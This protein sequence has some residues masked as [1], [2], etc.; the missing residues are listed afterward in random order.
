MKILQIFNK[1]LLPGGE[2]LA[3]NQIS[4]KLAT[5][6]VVR[7]LTF[8]TK[9]WVENESFLGKIMQA[10]HMVWNPA[11]I[12]Q[13]FK[14][15]EEFQPD[16]IILHNIM[17]IGSS[18]MYP[19]LQMRGVPIIQFIHNFRPFSVNGYCWADHQIQP[20]G[21]RL[22][23]LPEIRAAGWQNSRLKT[24]WYALQLR[25]LHASGTFQNINGWV[26]ISHFMADTFADCGIPA[27]K[28]RVIPHSWEIKQ[29]TYN[30]A[31][32]ADTEPTFLF[33]GRISEEK[34]LR[35]LLDA[36]KI[37]EQSGLP[38][39]LIIGGDGP[40]LD[41]AKALCKD[42]NHAT[43][44]GYVQGEAKE[45]LLKECTALVIPSIW[46][47]PMGLVIFEAFEFNKP[48]LAA[49]SG[50]IVDHVSDPDTGWLH[51][52]GDYMQLA[53]HFKEA[54]GNPEEIVRRGANARVY[55]ETQND[56]LWLERFENFAEHII[57]LH[58]DPLKSPIQPSQAKPNTKRKKSTLQVMTYL[59]DQNPRVGRSLGISRMTNIVM[60]SLAS[61]EDLELGAVVSRSSVKAPKNTQSVITL[62]WSTRG[63]VLRMF[64]DNLHPLFV[65]PNQRPDVWYFPKGFM[66]RISGA[67]T[68]SIATIHDTIIQYYQDNYPRWRLD[69]EYNYWSGMLKNTLI[70]A[71]E[72]MTV[73]NHAK[74][75]I[76]DFID[77]HHL[78][79]RHIH[80]TYE[81][82]LYE[83]IPQPRSS[84][85]SDY[86]MHLSSVEPHKR[87]KWL[88]D[89]WILRSKTGHK[90]H[91][92]KL[93]VIG[94]IP[95][96][97]LS[98]VEK[99]DWI[100]HL[101]FLEDN[102]LIRQ[103]ASAKALMLPSEIE[104]FGLPA[105]E[106][107]YLGTPTCFVKDTSVE[108]ILVPATTKGGF[109]LDQPDSLWGAL[110]EVLS[111]SEAEVYDCGIILRET[112]HTSKIANAMVAV[113]RE[114]AEIN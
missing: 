4:V 11:A 75:Q 27:E 86:V 26:A 111:M 23:F 87:T 96:D 51:E 108:E 72:I 109:H 48:V 81:P 44:L 45:K 113:F 92:P 8:H 106:A 42:M 61:R 74:S 15:I 89:Q 34:G 112:Y 24:A 33:L 52:P 3:V 60:R 90:Q 63:R 98:S 80:V 43:C 105:L 62:P 85:K 68:P 20:D 55:L 29:K 38:G 54:A 1:Y 58:K 57:R 73:S 67:M 102:E 104:G 64:T 59:A 28:I 7:D 71:S 21:L 32:P 46:W 69:I 82:C 103:Y 76:E 6:H 37:H 91:L 101:P 79:K 93:H 83:S 19:A 70:H 65:L 49:K 78:P 17:P 22:N 47:E 13:A 2:E 18:M 25:A 12:R 36:W 35:V 77:R 40:L 99:C 39:K 50:G 114:A 88:I 94:R 30:P 66:S 10:L 95:E 41:E 100:V 110:H 16:L 53:S 9:D 97:I 107:Y 56:K 31:S 14:E 84:E 5:R